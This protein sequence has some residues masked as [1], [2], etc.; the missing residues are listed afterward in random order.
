MRSWD[1]VPRSPSRASWRWSLGPRWGSCYEHG[2]ATGSAAV[3]THRVAAG[4]GL[5][6]LPWHCARVGEELLLRVSG[7][8]SAQAGSAMRG[9]RVHAALRR[10][11]RRCQ[12]AAL[13]APF[14]AGNLAE[15]IPSCVGGGTD[16]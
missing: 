15:L 14:E 10:S 6:G 12:H 7:A 11:F 4:D 13:G 8:A 5:F 16:R 9:V 2:R 1:G 3:L